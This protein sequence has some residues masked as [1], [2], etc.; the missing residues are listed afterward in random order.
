M[1]MGT[2][3]RYFFRFAGKRVAPNDLKKIYQIF[4]NQLPLFAEDYGKVFMDTDDVIRIEKI[5]TMGTMRRIE[6]YFYDDGCEADGDD[7][8]VWAWYQSKE[9]AQNDL[10]P[11]HASSLSKWELAAIAE[12]Q[13][14]FGII[15]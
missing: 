1:E 14:Y 15:S 13:K 6:I 8:R 11:K 2:D 7:F 4:E 9:E 10:A 12:V 3:S 5:D